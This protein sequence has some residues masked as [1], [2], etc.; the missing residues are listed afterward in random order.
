MPMATILGAINYLMMS[1]TF[2]L[3]EKLRTEKPYRR[4]NQ[5]PFFGKFL[6]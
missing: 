4:E 1:N 5:L 2:K 3:G 6:P